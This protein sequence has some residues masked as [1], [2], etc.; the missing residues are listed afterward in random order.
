MLEILRIYSY[1]VMG[2]PADLF[3]LRNWKI[4]DFIPTT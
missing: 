1:H 2:N 3:L 4:E